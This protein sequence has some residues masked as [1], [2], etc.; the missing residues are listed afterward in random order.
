MES[1]EN[2]D[3]KPFNTFG[4]S[5]SCRILYKIH[6]NGDILNILDKVEGPF[7]ILGGGSNLLLSKDQETVILKNEIFGKKVV[8]EN[9]DSIVIEVGGGEPW[10]AFVLWSIRQGFGGLENLSLI[11]GTVGAAPIQN[12][13]AYGVELDQVFHSLHAIHLKSGELHTFNTA[14]C[15]FGYRD[16]IF[17]NKLKGQF[18]ITHVNF[19]LTK[20]NHVLHL[21]YGAIKEELKSRNILTPDIKS[22]SDAV[23]AIRQSKLPDPAVLGNSG[24]FFKNP[25]VKDNF[26]SD[27]KTKY[28]SIPSY[29]HGEGEVKIPAGWL[30]EQAGWKGRRIED[31]GCYEKQAL[32]LVNYGKANGEQI[33]ELA[34]LI[35]EDVHSKF[36]ILLTPEVNII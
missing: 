2:I 28:P 26:F 8:E 18:F 23:I 27:L 21:D 15:H 10:H 4:I 29:P 1:F 19:K 30:I 22:I 5:A 35:I 3:L 33:L 24:S 36:D 12:I 20:Q 7:F 16:S 25:V 14:D 34:E 9:A 17:K 31:A 6:S 11:P 13:G 32:V